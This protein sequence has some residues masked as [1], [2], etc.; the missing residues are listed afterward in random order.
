M[1]DLSNGFRWVSSRPTCS[2]L[3][4]VLCSGQRVNKLS[5]AGAR[6]GS[7]EQSDSIKKKLK[8]DHIIDECRISW[9]VSCSGCD[10]ESGSIQMM[11]NRGMLTLKEKG[12]CSSTIA[13]ER[14]IYGNSGWNGP[15]GPVPL[16]HSNI[17]FRLRYIF[18][19]WTTTRSARQRNDPFHFEW[20]RGCCNSEVRDRP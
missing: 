5:T 17:I 12:D 18:H 3:C 19:I 11:Q 16:L 2:V 13:I 1:F 6:R 4:S 8:K 20:V 15:T 10:W 9:T 14:Y 7:Q